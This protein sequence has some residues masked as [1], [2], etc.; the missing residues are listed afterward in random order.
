MNKLVEGLTKPGNLLQRGTTANGAVTLT[1]TGSE[2]VDYFGVCGAARNMDEGDLISTFSSAY[3]ADALDAMKILFF[4]RDIRGGAGERETFRKVLHFLANDET[5]CESLRK[6]LK[7][8]PHFGRWDDLFVLIGTPLQED[9]I[10]L[11]YVQL[12]D[13][14]GAINYNRARDTKGRSHVIETLMANGNEDPSEEEIEAGLVPRKEISL[15]AKWMPSNNTSSKATRRLA[16]KLGRLLQAKVDA[17]NKANHDPKTNTSVIEDWS[18]SPAEYRKTLSYIRKEINLLERKLSAGKWSEV[19]YSKIPSKAGMLYRKAFFKRDGERYQA[20]MDEVAKGKVTVNAGALH[21]HEIIQ[22]V[23]TLNPDS[24]S[25]YYEEDTTTAISPEELAQE[26]LVLNNYW[27][28]LAEVLLGMLSDE[29]TIVVADTSGSMEMPVGPK[30]K[31]TCLD[32]SIGLAILFSEKLG[33]PFRDRFISFSSSPTLEEVTG[34]DIYEKYHNVKPLIENT[35]IQ[36]VF[37]LILET[38]VRNSVPA[39]DMPRRVLIISDMEFDDA[40]YG[41]EEKF[42][43]TNLEVLKEKYQESGYDLPE[44]VFWNVNARP[45]NMPMSISDEGTCMVSGYSPA[46]YQSVLKAEVITPADVMRA[47]I[48]DERYDCVEA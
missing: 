47:A 1:T 16:G 28:N 32:V 6:N 18:F 26:R 21:P 48:D 46:I 9:V 11:I 14:C 4:S 17:N 23:R 35:D 27:E 25:W 19:D 13:D 29:S 34:E 30:S 24:R 36:K 2:L 41:V 10:D 5:R 20:F 8:V 33:G 7:L 22:K 37:D 38:G 3:G 39:D 44:L 40:Q 12:W 31:A 43:K 15:L 45:D 42:G